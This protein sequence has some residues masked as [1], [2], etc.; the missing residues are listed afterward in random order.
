MVCVCIC[1]G[2][3]ANGEGCVEPKELC[4]KAR[5]TS[6]IKGLVLQRFD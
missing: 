3:G 6:K 5:G 1:V 4:A 2:G